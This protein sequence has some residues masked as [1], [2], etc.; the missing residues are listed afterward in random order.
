MTHQPPILDALFDKMSQSVDVAP[1]QLWPPKSEEG[2]LSAVDELIR[3]GNSILDGITEG[4]WDFDEWPDKTVISS[5]EGELI[6]LLPS[7]LIQERSANNARFIKQARH[8]LPRFIAALQNLADQV[9]T[10]AAR[11]AAGDDALPGAVSDP[12][13]RVL[14]SLEIEEARD[15]TVWQSI[16]GGQAQFR[17]SHWWTRSSSRAF[18][19]NYLPLSY[20]GPGPYTQVQS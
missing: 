19:V 13:T 16:S 20:I 12:D 18:W 10:E 3:E 15:G 4:D 7:V 11:V 17:E 6:A 8:L 14:N 5:N 1:L 2:N 9:D